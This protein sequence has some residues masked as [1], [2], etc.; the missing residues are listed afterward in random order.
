MLVKAVIGQPRLKRR[1]DRFHFLMVKCQRL[2][3]HLQSPD[4]H[5]GVHTHTHTHT[6]THA[7]MHTGTHRKLG[8]GVE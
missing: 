2:C 6:H 5:G 1:A 3:S 7:R 4:T 8:V